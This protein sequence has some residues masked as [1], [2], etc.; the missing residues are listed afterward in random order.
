MC[1]FPLFETVSIIDGQIQNL[2]YHQQRFQ[3]A[4]REYFG[5]EPKFTLLQILL[6]PNTYQKGKVRCRIDYN[7]TE[8]EIKFF[9]YSPKQVQRFRCVEVENWDYHLKFS[10]RKQFDFLNILQN[11]EVIIINNGNVSDCSMGNLLFLKAGIWY[12]SQDYLLKGTQLTRLLEQQK[13]HLIKII[14]ADLGEY[15]KIM[16]INA[17]NPFDESRALLCSQIYF[18]DLDRKS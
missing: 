17:L 5:C 4:V 18:C 3:Q 12:S 10:D 14:K 2:P 6:V 13:V 11:E 1:Q 7:A 8:F 16:L 9:D 15:E